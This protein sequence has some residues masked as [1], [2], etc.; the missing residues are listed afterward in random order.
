MDIHE[1]VCYSDSLHCINLIKGLNINYHVYIALIQDIKELIAQNNITFCHTLREGNN[2]ADF[3]IKLG[4][5]LDYELTIH[6][7][8]NNQHESI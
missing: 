5:S 3:L 8:H 6:A 4:A 1:L 2:F 7:S